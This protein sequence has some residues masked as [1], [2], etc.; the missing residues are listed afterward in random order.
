[1]VEAGARYLSFVHFESGFEVAFNQLSKSMV[2]HPERKIDE[3]L[4]KLNQIFKKENQAL[5]PSLE[6]QRY[7]KAQELKVIGS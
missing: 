4:Q 6:N 1:M 2:E 3:K 7:L 5:K